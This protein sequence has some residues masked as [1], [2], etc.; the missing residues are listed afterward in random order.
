VVGVEVGEG[1]LQVIDQSRSHAGLDDNVIDVDLQVVADLPPK[2]LLDAPLE[3]GSSIPEAEGH[4][5]VTKG[6]ERGDEQ[7]G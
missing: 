2:T 5:S 6:T 3:G 1:L 4:G 7:S